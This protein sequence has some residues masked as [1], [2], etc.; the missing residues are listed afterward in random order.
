MRRLPCIVASWCTLACGP[1]IP[2]SDDDTTTAGTQPTTS[3]TSSSTSTT[4]DP[5]GDPTSTTLSTSPLPTT[6][7][8][9][10]GTSTTDAETE[11]TGCFDDD[12]ICDTWLQNCCPGS[13]CL[14]WANDGTTSWNDFRC[15]PIADAP[16]AIGEP[17]TV[18]GSAISGIDSCVKEAFCFYIDPEDNTGICAATCSGTPD[19][20][21]CDDPA[22]ICAIE[23][24]GYIALCL[25]ACDPLLDDCD[26]GICAPSR[27]NFVCGLAMGPDNAIGDECQGQWDC[28][29]GGIC[30]SADRLPACEGSQCCAAYCDITLPDPCA[31]GLVCDPW[32]REGQGPGGEPPIGVCVVG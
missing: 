31:E 3:S 30:T 28:A 21:Y 15:S 11:T 32:Y 2:P 25:D 1:V 10:H 17:C 14:P 6:D 19:E 20:P 16:D 4:L 5:S 24:G 9:T 27:D 13:K 7:P 22:T 12:T 18:E 23:F 29:S 26:V 8:T